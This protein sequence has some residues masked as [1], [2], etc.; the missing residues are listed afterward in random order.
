[1]R[2]LAEP[3]L[4]QK[5]KFIAAAQEVEGSE[6]AFNDALKRIGKATVT[7]KKK[8]KAKSK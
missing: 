1:M 8:A 6:K 4:T 5:E 7:A 3:K 2:K